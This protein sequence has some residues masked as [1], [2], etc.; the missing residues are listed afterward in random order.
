MCTAPIKTPS[1]LVRRPFATDAYVALPPR[2]AVF[3][4][5]DVI[6]A[7]D[8][9]PHLVCVH[10]SS[11]SDHPNHRA[12]TLEYAQGRHVRS[13]TRTQTPSFWNAPAPFVC[14]TTISMWLR[15]S[16]AKAGADR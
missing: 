15:V 4:H 5:S 11:V 2:R 1:R 16:D 13:S 6:A 8:H 3:G 12:D 9:C 14:S 7:V 10:H